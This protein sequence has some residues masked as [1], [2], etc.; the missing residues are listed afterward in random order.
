MGLG[1]ARPWAAARDG[2]PTGTDTRSELV[3]RSVSEPGVLDA[4]RAGQPLAG[5]RS[6]PL[7]PP[8]RSLDVVPPPSEV[9]VR[10]AEESDLPAVTEIYNE[11]IRTTTG[12]FDTEPRSIADRTAWFRSHDARHP[13]FVAVVGVEV[14]GW[15]ALTAWSDRAAYR[16][17]GEV[18]V[19]VA[20]THRGGGVGRNLLGAIVRAAADLEF[21]TVLARVAEGNEASLRL[22]L[23]AGFRL[24]G[25]MREVGNKFGQ[26]L[27]V[28]LLQ[29]MLDPA[30]GNASLLDVTPPR[31]GGVP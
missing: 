4:G 1:L 11:A 24:V 28:R 6:A 5:E 20:E 9:R 29:R 23:G 26:R 2:A 22:H 25:V 12:T 27:D 17:T 14:V 21:H 18:S 15:G 30:P 19:Y 16:A 3:H 7:K 8:G 13:V 31:A 10:P